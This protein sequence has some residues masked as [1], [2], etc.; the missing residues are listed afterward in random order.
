MSEHRFKVNLG[1]MIEILS[2]HLYSDPDVYI[3]ELLQNAVVLHS[4]A[5]LASGV[6]YILPY[7]VQPTIR[8]SHLIYL[9]NT[10]LTTKGEDLLPDWAFFTKC[11]VNTKNLRP[12]AS[13][14]S[15]Y[16]DEILEQTSEELGECIIEY[17]TNLANGNR[18]LFDQFMQ[19]HELAIRSIAVTDEEMFDVFIDSLLFH[20]TKGY[21]TGRDLKLMHEEL[22]YAG[23]MEYK[24]LS[25]I[26]MAQNKLLIDVGYVYTM[27][28]L[29]RL[30]EKTGLDPVKVFAIYQ[31]ILKLSDAIIDQKG[32]DPYH[33][34][35]LWRY[36]WLL[37][38]GWEFYQ[39]TTPQFEKLLQDSVIRY[40]KAGYTFRSLYMSAVEYYYDIDDEKAKE[41]YQLY[42]TQ[43]RDSMTDCAACEISSEIGYDLHLDK[44]SEARKKAEN[45]I[46]G[47]LN[48]TVQPYSVY[49]T[50]IDY[51]VEKQ[52]Y[53]KMLPAGL[54]EELAGFAADARKAIVKMGLLKVNTG[55][56]LQYYALF[57]PNKAINLLKQFPDFTE[58]VVSPLARFKFA[59]GMMLFIQRLGN[60]KTYKMKIDSRFPFYNP[61]NVYE[62]AKMYDYYEGIARQIAEDF[63]KSQGR[64]ILKK[65]F[66][67][68]SLRKEN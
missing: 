62:P 66:E 22:V 47:R 67:K 21:V 55:L 60:K 40:K 38:D 14:E 36:K 57:E 28:L 26:F 10:L 18:A 30:S 51:A 53:G 24:H 59:L 39:V 52:L 58:T 9:K 31:A 5:G 3:R 37:G 23:M 56:L 41:Y 46:S 32:S 44:Y 49:C 29:S 19:I 65:Y 33:Y 68:V 35:V 8:Q 7:T 54:G 61:E 1:G 34:N 63:Y 45:V 6:A 50:L 15:F 48:C 16:R 25:Q 12:T 20:T 27:E 13:R 17:L 42:L 43:K 2:D 64:V 11:I 4:E